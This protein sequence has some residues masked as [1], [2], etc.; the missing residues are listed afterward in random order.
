MGNCFNARN[1]Y[2]EEPSLESM[3][4]VFE[5]LQLSPKD[6]GR[7]FHMFCTFDAD[8][9]GLVNT[10]ELFA[11]L[12]KD[13]VN[14]RDRVFAL[15]DEDNSGQIDF[16]EYVLTL[17]NYCTLSKAS[18]VIFAFDLYDTASAGSLSMSDIDAMIT[19]LYGELAATHPQA[20]Q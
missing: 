16:R 17:W 11:T 18:L 1:I 6:V 9:S 19:D 10:H 8:R 14:F 7:L 5:S 13:S 4:P 3:R 12:A 15:F 20:Q 2:D